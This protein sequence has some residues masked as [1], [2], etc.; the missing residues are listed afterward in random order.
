MKNL[1]WVSAGLLVLSW[2]FK[3]SAAAPEAFASINVELAAAVQ[4]EPLSLNV[5]DVTK[6]RWLSDAQLAA[7]I[8]VLAATPTIAVDDLPNKG[9]GGTYYSLQHPEWPPLPGD[10]SFS[11]AWII[12]STGAIDKTYL[13]SDLDFVYGATAKSKTAMRAMSPS[14]F[15][16]EGSDWL[17]RYS[18]LCFSNVLCL[19]IIS[20]D[21][22]N[23]VA[24]LLLHN[25]TNSYFYQLLSKTNLLQPVWTLGTIQDGA[26]GTNQ[27]DFFPVNLD[28]NPMIFFGHIRR[29]GKFPSSEMPT[30]LNRTATIR[31][32]WAVLFCQGTG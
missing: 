26:S 9:A 27:T 20:V 23:Q 18:M 16:G 8:K 13:L 22:T 21:L 17:N 15:E 29:T 24:D 1:K 4:A 32:S 12:G 5:A 2:V 14:G 25:T 10:T 30:P 11:P 19:E 3:S 31:G 7:L 28:D 6:F